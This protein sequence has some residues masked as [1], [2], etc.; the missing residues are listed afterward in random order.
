MSVLSAVKSFN[1]QFPLKIDDV[2]FNDVKWAR[3]YNYTTKCKGL[4]Y[5]ISSVFISSLCRFYEFL[6]LC[7]NWE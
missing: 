5:L 1:G 3:L 6:L 7:I 2:L 4:P